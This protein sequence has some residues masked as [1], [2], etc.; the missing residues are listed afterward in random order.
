MV[1]EAPNGAIR[2]VE[3]NADVL[4]SI[5]DGWN[6]QRALWELRKEILTSFF[7]GDWPSTS[8]L[9]MSNRDNRYFD[10]VTHCVLDALERI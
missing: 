8:V 10:Q 5:V 3:I 2:R 9:K 6:G 1:I 7:A 4:A